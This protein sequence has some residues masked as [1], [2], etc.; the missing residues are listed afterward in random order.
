MAA[1]LRLVFISL[2]DR[3]SLSTSETVAL[4]E[5]GC[6]LADTE[7]PII[8]FTVKDKE[9][10]PMDSEARPMKDET[11]GEYRFVYP[12]RLYFSE[13]FYIFLFDRSFKS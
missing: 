2:S 1:S 8:S 3:K 11:F 13:A 12:N 5:H 7:N 6:D 4:E 9:E 10:G